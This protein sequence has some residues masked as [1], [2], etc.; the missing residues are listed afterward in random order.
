[1]NYFKLDEFNKA[2]VDIENTE[3]VVVLD[4]QVDNYHFITFVHRG[5]IIYV[6]RNDAAID[7]NHPGRVM[8][9]VNRILPDGCNKTQISFFE[10]YEGM[11]SINDFLDAAKFDCQSNIQPIH[12]RYGLMPS[13]ASKLISKIVAK[14]GGARE[15][16]VLD[17]PHFCVV[18]ETWNKEH[19][20][21][22]V[23]K[24]EQDFYGHHDGFQVDLVTESICG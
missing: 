4:K 13:D 16:G 14:D 5:Y 18:S 3:G 17:A 20:V 22:D 8:F 9:M 15:K 12:S 10:A 21:I 11:K 23:L 19:R 24:T 7:E 6:Q 2:I 1:M